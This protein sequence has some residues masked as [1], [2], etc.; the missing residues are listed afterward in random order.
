VIL[1]GVLD[2]PGTANAVPSAL[3]LCTLMMEVIRSSETSALTRAT[4]RH[5]PGDGIH[6]E[7]YLFYIY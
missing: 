6:K 3:I 7:S 4:R 1:R 2:L 5:I